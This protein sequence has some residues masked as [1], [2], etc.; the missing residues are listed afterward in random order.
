MHAL[1]PPPRG[2]TENILPSEKHK[3][4]CHNQANRFERS[5]CYIQHTHA[6]THTRT[7]AHTW[8]SLLLVA[9]LRT[10]RAVRLLD[11]LVKSMFLFT[12]TTF[13]AACAVLFVLFISQVRIVHKQ[14]RNFCPRPRHSWIRLGRARPWWVQTR[15][16]K[17]LTYLHDERIGICSFLFCGN[18]DLG[19]QGVA[20][21]SARARVCVCVHVCVCVCMCVIHV[22]NVS[23]EP[24]RFVFMGQGF[25]LGQPPHPQALRPGVR[26][27][28]ADF[29]HFL[30]VCDDHDRV[31]GSL[32]SMVTRR[33]PLCSSLPAFSCFDCTKHVLRERRLQCTRL[34]KLTG[35][36]RGR[37]E[38]RL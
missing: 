25:R 13:W 3:H 20:M 26:T 7:H 9:A 4:L 12:H 28:T 2:Q 21:R 18:F 31:G 16:G 23:T 15:I 27:F 37:T 1:P 19:D 38:P 11:K 8:F 30:R 24:H 14:R 35:R 36:N 22:S 17:N 33:V 5:T 6:N 10:G 29:R 32:V 34:S